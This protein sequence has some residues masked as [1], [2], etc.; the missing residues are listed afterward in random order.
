MSVAQKLITAEIGNLRTGITESWCEKK[1][2]KILVSFTWDQKYPLSLFVGST[3]AP[4][5]RKCPAV[6]VNE[7][8][9]M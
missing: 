1:E 2:K 6:L 8:F 3:A 5:N 7:I 9:I 4:Q